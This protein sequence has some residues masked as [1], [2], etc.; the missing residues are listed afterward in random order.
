MTSYIVLYW[1]L[2]VLVQMLAME[3]K[4]S[5][6]LAQRLDALKW[7]VAGSAASDDSSTPGE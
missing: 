7:A 6:V 3:E 1:Q 2:E 5:E 4:K